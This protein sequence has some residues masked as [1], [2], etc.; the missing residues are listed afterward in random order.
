MSAPPKWF[1]DGS[2]REEEERGGSISDGSEEKG[3]GEK[4]EEHFQSQQRSA[5]EEEIERS[6]SFP[7]TSPRGLKGK[8]LSPFLF[9]KKTFYRSIFSSLQ[10]VLQ[11]FLKE[12]DEEG[13]RKENISGDGMKKKGGVGALYKHCSQENCAVAPTIQWPILQN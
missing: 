11:G 5:E 12:E 3:A 8:K 4:E 9:S 13:I 10:I 7:P 1:H 2:G 6:S